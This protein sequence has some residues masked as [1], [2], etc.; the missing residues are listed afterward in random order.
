MGLFD[1]IRGE[2]IDIIEWQDTTRDTIVRRFPR[3][4]KKVYRFMIDGRTGEV[5]GERPW[6]IVRIT[7]AAAAGIALLAGVRHFIHPYLQ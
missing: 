2:F 5:Q 6:S 4:N 1:K 3:Y 7:L